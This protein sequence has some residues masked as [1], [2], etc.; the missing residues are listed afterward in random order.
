MFHNIRLLA[1]KHSVRV[2]SFVENDEEAELVRAVE[3]IC[4]SVA[5]IKRIPDLSAHWFSLEP[6]LIREF[7]TPAMHKAVDD[8]LR[9]KRADIIQ[10][11]YLQMAQYRRPGFSSILTIHEAYSANAYKA[12]Q[13][14]TDAVEKFR[15]FSRWMA[16]LNF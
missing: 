12:F 11:E 10:C 1:E 4:E 6:F 13:A 5:A 3:P 15:L 14:A 2:L 9:T 7:N 8:A 16:M